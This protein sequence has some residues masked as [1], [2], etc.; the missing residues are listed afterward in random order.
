MYQTRFLR[1]DN[2]ELRAF[3]ARCALWLMEAWSYIGADDAILRR[4]LIRAGADLRHVL[5]LS[6]MARLSFHRVRHLPARGRRAAA[7]RPMRRVLR[8]L[9]GGAF[10]G[11]NSGAIRDRIA[12]LQR[13]IDAQ[14]AI[15][16]RIVSRILRA[17]NKLKPAPARHD[18]LRALGA[19]CAAPNAPLAAA[20]TS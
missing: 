15:I 10:A 20:D 9:S 13:L 17:Y 7:F 2:A 1:I 18:I 14:E 6:A 8:A 4:G 11:L 16:A 3:L 12:R 19:P 5:V